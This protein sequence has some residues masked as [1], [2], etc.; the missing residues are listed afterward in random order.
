MEQFNQYSFLVSMITGLVTGIFGFK[1][2]QV[3]QQKD[4]ADMK[5]KI[6]Q[7][8]SARIHENEKLRR[9]MEERYSAIETR[10]SALVA[11]ISQF[12]EET[13]KGIA[14]LSATMKFIL[15]VLDNK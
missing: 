11:S 6:Q 12:R 1:I 5:A 7:N 9:D 2:T 4:I 3:L 8:E 14:E 15:K 10:N 13:V